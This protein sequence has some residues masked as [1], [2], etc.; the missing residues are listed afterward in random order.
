VHSCIY[1]IELYAFLKD[2]YLHASACL[3]VQV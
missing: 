3:S 1:L 2:T